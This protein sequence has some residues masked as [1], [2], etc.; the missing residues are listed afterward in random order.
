M[1][2]ALS[3]S[4]TALALAIDP[5]ATHGPETGKIVAYA[6]T[7]RRLAEELASGVFVGNRTF[8]VNKARELLD[9]LGIKQRVNGG[10]LGVPQNAALSES[11]REE[12]K[13]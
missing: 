2:D 6:N 10:I 7:T 8:Q 3:K 1:L 11:A 13:P 5:T 9:H 4:V 12:S